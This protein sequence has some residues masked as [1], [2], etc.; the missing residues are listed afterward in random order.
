MPAATLW[1]KIAQGETLNRNAM[2]KSFI[3]DCARR[4]DENTLIP[5][6]IPNDTTVRV[7]TYNVHMWKDAYGVRNFD[8]IMD[9]ITKMNADVLV[10]QEVVLF[11]KEAISQALSDAGY[12]CSILGRTTRSGNFFGNL[13]VSKYPFAQKPTVKTYDADKKNAGERRCFIK[14]TVQLPHDKKIT[15]Y[16]THLDVYD[17]TE[18]L[19]TAEIKELITAIDTTK[20]NCI[21]A[22]DFNAIRQQDY[23]YYIENK[24]VWDMLN[25]GNKKR[26]GFETQ[27][28]ALQTL[29]NNKFTDSFTKNMQHGPRYTVWSGTAVDFMYLNPAWQLPLAGNYVYQSSASDHL[30]IIMDVNIK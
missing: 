22:A 18:N 8:A 20:E 2:I 19:R 14:A 4:E 17:Q 29:H 15:V 26:T 3:A 28:K 23:Q 1:Q 13:V 10:L 6:H 12:T 21:I 27:T 16:G 30:P 5:Q 25:R 9:T 24:S 7:A 11:D